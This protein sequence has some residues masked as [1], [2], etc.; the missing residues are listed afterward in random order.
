[1]H[2]VCFLVF[3]PADHE[4][5]WQVCTGVVDMAA[6][7]INMKSR[8]EGENGDGNEDE[9]G[10]EHEGRHGAESWSKN[11]EK[12]RYGGGGEKERRVGRRE[13]GGGDDSE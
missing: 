11:G 1:M 12:N 10:N 8:R 7:S 4:S 2:V 6:Q 5:G 3:D 9:Y 13:T